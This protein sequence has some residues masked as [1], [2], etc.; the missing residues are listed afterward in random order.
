MTEKI[1]MATLS[2][3]KTPAMVNTPKIL[4]GIAVVRIMGLAGIKWCK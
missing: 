3:S 1:L 4:S 2:D